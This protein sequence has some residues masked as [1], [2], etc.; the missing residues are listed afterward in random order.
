MSVGTWLL[1][2]GT[3]LLGRGEYYLFGFALKG[4]NVPLIY[5]SVLL[6]S[7]A[8]SLPDTMISVRDAKKGNFQDA[9]SNAFGSNIFD[10]SFALG[11]PLL[12]YTI[13]YQPITMDIEVRIWSM[14][15]W[16][17]LLFINIIVFI[18]MTICT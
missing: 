10:I 4:L 16:I 13:M 12:A 11:L 1:V 17:M 2:L 8:S 3:E 7:A 14:S 15:M 6:A 9:L 5:I 18:I